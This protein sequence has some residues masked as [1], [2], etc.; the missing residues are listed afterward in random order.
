MRGLFPASPSTKSRRSSPIGY[1]KRHSTPL[2]WEHVVDE[3]K[4][5]SYSMLITRYI[6]RC[7]GNDGFCTRENVASLTA[8]AGADERY[9]H[10]QVFD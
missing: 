6:E 10:G 3:T 9:V 7:H 5:S 2:S 8:A 1:R 4:S